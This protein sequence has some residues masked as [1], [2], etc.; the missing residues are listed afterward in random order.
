M[1]IFSTVPFT[2][3]MSMYSPLRKAS[4]MRKN[5]PEKMS[6][7]RVWAP[8][9]MARPT[10]PAP[11]NNGP[12]STPISDSEVTEILSLMTDSETRPQVTIGLD[13]GDQVKIN[14]GPFDG[15]DGTVDEVNAEKGT[16]RVIVTIFGRP[17]PV[18]LKYW[19]VDSV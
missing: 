9:P 17:T 18:D 7:I 10:T 12:I 8:K 13:K 16:V 19:E 1:E 4:S 14:T 3:P 6:L 11:A 15:F 2:V 5:A